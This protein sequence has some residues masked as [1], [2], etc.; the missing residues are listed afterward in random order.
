V[1]RRRDDERREK[2]Q[3]L[4]S[5]K[6]TVKIFTPEAWHPSLGNGVAS[7]AFAHKYYW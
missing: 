7:H 3:L 5:R 4:F 1:D 6:T 2:G